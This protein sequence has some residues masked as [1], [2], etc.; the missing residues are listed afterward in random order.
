VSVLSDEGTLVYRRPG[1]GPQDI[2]YSWLTRGDR[3]APAPFGPLPRSDIPSFRVSPDGRQVVYSQTVGTDDPRL[4]V[5]DL[6]T[7]SSRTIVTG[8][9]YWAIWTPDGRRVIYQEPSGK[10]KAA[11]FS[12]AWRPVDG[13]ASAERLTTTTKGWQQPQFVTR[14]GR[15]LVYEESGGVG[16]E[17]PKEQTYDLWLLPLEP[18]GE[19]RG[20]LRTKAN[21]RLAHLS[22]DQRWMAYVSDETGR[23]EVW[24]RAFLGGTA[25]VQVSQEG[26]TEPLWAPDGRTLYYRDWSGTML[27]AVP[28]TAG[29][30]PQFGAPVV[31]RGSWSRG[32]PFGRRYDVDPVSGALLF[33]SATTF[34][35]EI[36][37]VLNFDE[38]IRRKAAGGR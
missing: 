12:L 21:E 34:G 26:G 33:Q 13:S 37:V 15:F 14:D 25:S 35:R 24:V 11:G 32:L 27:H 28:V 6:A 31:T 5:A 20:L 4:V 16:A 30:V 8:P 36:R 3:P 19:P 10:E 9:H 2:R 18:H 1:G 29:T 23:D 38:V 7:R 17:D 22:P